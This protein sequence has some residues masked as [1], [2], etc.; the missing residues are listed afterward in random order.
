MNVDEKVK[1][2]EEMWNKVDALEEKQDLG[3]TTDEYAKKKKITYYQA[4]HCL[5]RYVIAGKLIQGK[6]RGAGGKWMNVFTLPE[7]K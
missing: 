3:F 5:R 4:R 2:L 1:Q 6:K 7:E